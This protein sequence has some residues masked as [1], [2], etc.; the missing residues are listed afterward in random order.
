VL[1]RSGSSA[2]GGILAADGNQLLGLQL[3]RFSLGTI[4]QKITFSSGALYTLSFYA[5]SDTGGPATFVVYVGPIAVLTL[6]SPPTMVMTFYSVS[7]I[8]DA[9]SQSIS[10][11][12]K[13]GASGGCVAFIDMV[14]I[15]QGLFL[16]MAC[17]DCLI[18]IV[19]PIISVIVGAVTT[20]DLLA[21]EGTK[22]DIFTYCG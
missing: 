17:G 10:F 14:M 19:H 7:F 9:S 20:S 6:V 2:Y 13:C 8:A 1:I 15:T 12:S 21:V 4:L 5:A 3:P 22:S 11:E 18:D 16:L